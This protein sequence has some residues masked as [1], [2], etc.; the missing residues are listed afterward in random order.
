MTQPNKDNY[1]DET[2]TCNQ[3][4]ADAA[5]TSGWLRRALA[6]LIEAIEIDGTLIHSCQCDCETCEPLKASREALK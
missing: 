3:R 1:T 5:N 6:N 4:L 2:P